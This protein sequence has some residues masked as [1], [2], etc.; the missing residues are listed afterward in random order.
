MDI[1]EILIQVAIAALSVIGLYGIL[2]G[3]LE[4]FAVPRAIVTAVVIQ[5]K[6]PPEELDMLLCEA[7]RAPFG[8]RG[9]PILL[10]IHADLMDGDMGQGG[11]LFEEYA[12]LAEEYGAQVC[13]MDTKETEYP[14]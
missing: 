6:T 3:F 9:R 1:K 11:V 13:L 8:G 14:Q 12:T 10:V 7:R 5:S 4:G 2:H